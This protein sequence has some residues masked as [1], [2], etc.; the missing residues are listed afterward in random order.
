MIGARAHYC[1]PLALHHNHALSRLYTDIWAGPLLRHAGVCGWTAM[2]SLAARRHPALPTRRVKSFTATMLGR[3]LIQIVRPLSQHDYEGV[4]FRY[5]EEGQN[6]AAKVNRHLT[7]TWDRARPTGL[8][9]YTTGCLETLQ[10]FKRH[11]LPT[12]VDQID[13]A[14]THEQVLLEEHAKWPGWQ[15]AQGR[16]PSEYWQRLEMEWKLADRIMVNSEWTRKALMAQGV[17]ADKIFVIP[18]AYEA[19]VEPR[20]TRKSR[21][22]VALYL[23]RV[24]LEKG[25]P[26]LFEAARQLQHEPIRFVLAG[27]IGISTE[28]VKSAPSN[29][30]LIGPISRD[31]LGPVYSA[32]DLCVLPTMSDGFALTQL[33]AMAHGLPV[34][35]TPNCGDV[36][37]DG[38]DGRIVPAGDAA[39]LV[40]AIGE[41]IADRDRLAEFSRQALLKATQFDLATYSRRLAKALNGVETSH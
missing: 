29:V 30:K 3:R 32:A 1:L 14:R 25:I 2:R 19:P 37:S 41:L 27:P 39:A 35:T 9:A 26:Y 13:A 23:G 33:E 24:V 40:A 20:P 5:I 36:V 6:F 31:R 7:K 38:V 16:V 15:P 28:A 18:L 34:I 8:I 11:G 4:Y 21:Q 22:L 17:A 10:L 12:V